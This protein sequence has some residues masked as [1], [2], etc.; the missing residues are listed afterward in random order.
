MKTVRTRVSIDTP[1]SAIA[2]AVAIGLVYL[3]GLLLIHQLVG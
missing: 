2:G 3:A 1:T